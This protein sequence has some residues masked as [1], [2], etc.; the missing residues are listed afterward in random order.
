MKWERE[1]EREE[2]DEEEE[3][4][5]EEEVSIKLRIQNLIQVVHNLLWSNL[6]LKWFCGGYHKL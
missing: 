2:E 5:E 1:R 6:P 3:E 4:E